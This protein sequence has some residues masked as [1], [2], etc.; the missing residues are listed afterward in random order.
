MIHLHAKYYQNI[1]SSLEII[2]SVSVSEKY[3]P[4][5]LFTK[6]SGIRHLHAK[7]YQ[8]IPHGLEVITSV[9][10]GETFASV[11]LF[12]KEIWHLRISL[13]RSCQYLFACQN[14][15]KYSW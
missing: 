6:K 1:P 9:S 5:S 11:R 3:A 2:T 8:N 10:V 15:L 12:I 4:A 14:L 7:N 13:V